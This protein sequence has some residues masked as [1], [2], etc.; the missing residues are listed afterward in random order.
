MQEDRLD[1]VEM[2]NLLVQRFMADEY[3]CACLTDFCNKND[4]DNSIYYLPGINRSEWMEYYRK[5]LV[6]NSFILVAIEE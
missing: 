4:F 6:F 1:I 2:L 5:A 3:S